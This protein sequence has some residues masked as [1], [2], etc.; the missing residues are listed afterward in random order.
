MGAQ[1]SDATYRFYTGE[2]RYDFRVA[3]LT[4]ISSDR[5]RT[6]ELSSGETVRFDPHFDRFVC[7]DPTLSLQMLRVSH[8]GAMTRKLL[9]MIDDRVINLSP[10]EPDQFS[11]N[12]SVGDDGVATVELISIGLHLDF[13]TGWVDNRM[14]WQRPREER[15]QRLTNAQGFVSKEQQARGLKFIEEVVSI[16][17]NMFNGEAAWGR[18]KPGRLVL[19]KDIELKISMGDLIDG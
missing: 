15:Y 6:H 2:K 9:L 3:T 4:E 1:T 13:Y 8:Q 19:S 5:V 18:E 16:Y 7:S 11:D 14:K 12:I 10:Q 17:G